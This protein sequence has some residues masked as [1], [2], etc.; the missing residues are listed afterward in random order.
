M[1]KRIINRISATNSIFME[2][3]IQQKLGKFMIK[4]DCM[5]HN[6]NRLTRVSKIFDIPIIA[7]RHVQK[8]FG[9][10]DER[11]TSVTHPKRV[12]FDKTLFSM[13][14]EPVLNHLKAQTGRN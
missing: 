3:D 6:A 13:L 11:I 1:N 12:L 10:I 14:E 5:A 8:N 4:N 9:D 7:T 2:C